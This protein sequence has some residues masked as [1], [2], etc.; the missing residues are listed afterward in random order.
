MSTLVVFQ[1]MLVIFILIA[2][3]YLL[4][5][6]GCISDQGTRLVS[7]L[8]AN[9]T[10]PA[11]ILSSV[12]DENTGITHRDI[13]QMFLVTAI[14]Y[15]ILI[16]MGWLLPKIYRIPKEE[17]KF[18]HLM[19]VYANTG[20]IGIPLVSAVLGSEALIFVTIVNIVFNLLFYTHGLRVLTAGTEAGRQKI[21]W[22]TFLNV[23][24]L[25]S[26]L[27][28]LIFW[29]QIPL[30]VVVEDS[31]LYIGRSTTF[32]SM[33]VLG[34]S[35]ANT[36]FSA[37]FKDVRTFLYVLAC[38]LALPML[39]CLGMQQWVSHPMILYVSTLM[40]AM[41]CANLPLIVAQQYGLK[42]DILSRGIIQSTLIS[43]LTITLVTTIL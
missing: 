1:Q 23:G 31:V 9:V 35:L 21:S 16:A 40:L 30:P 12:L 4:R 39:L 22:R 29:F 25:M 42:A 33:L 34:V 8:V 18:Y 37:I 27:A 32:L 15:A 41:P 17:Q 2:V 13:L 20:F 24:T 3:G 6:K 36:S 28:L 11:L 5:K 14:L 26:L 43:I 10:N 38:M 19:T 7:F